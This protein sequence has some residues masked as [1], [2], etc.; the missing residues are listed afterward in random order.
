MHCSLE[1]HDRTKRECYAETHMAECYN[2]G[3]YLDV[4]TLIIEIQG[5]FSPQTEKDW[6]KTQIQNT[7]QGGSHVDNFI[8]RWLSLFRQSKISNIF[9]IEWFFQIEFVFSKEV[10][11]A[12]AKVWSCCPCSYG[13]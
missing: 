13:E 3:V 4:N 1:L 5:F 9:R 2:S 12:D 8:A 10:G 6:A 7:K 11:P